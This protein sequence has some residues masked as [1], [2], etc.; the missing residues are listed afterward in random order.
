M[1]YN[2]SEHLK[3]IVAGTRVPQTQSASLPGEWMCI[4]Y[5]AQVAENI[6]FNCTLIAMISEL[7]SASKMFQ[8]AL[9]E[10]FSVKLL[11]YIAYLLVLFSP[12]S[13]TLKHTP[14]Y[15]F[16]GGM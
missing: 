6:L 14:H 7:F 15:T 1:L 11:L 8:C 3:F 16:I 10:F 2:P 4:L 5:N 9:N 12:F 13:H